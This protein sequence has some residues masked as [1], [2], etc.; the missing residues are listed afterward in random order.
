M[1]KLLLLLLAWVLLSVQINYAVSNPRNNDSASGNKAVQPKTALDMPEKSNFFHI[2][3]RKVAVPQSSTSNNHVQRVYLYANN[4][5]NARIFIMDEKISSESTAMKILLQQATARGNYKPQVKQYKDV[6][7]IEGTDMKMN[8]RYIIVLDYN[9]A[10]KRAMIRSLMYQKKP[11][12]RD[13]FLIA[14]SVK[15]TQLVDELLHFGLN[16]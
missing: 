6:Q 12:N 11:K 4:Y 2:A 13:F 15:E 16:L 10:T 5:D 7:Y 3:F 1:K 8:G 9:K 14:N